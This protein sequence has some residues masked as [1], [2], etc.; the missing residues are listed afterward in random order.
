VQHAWPADQ[1]HT[2]VNLAHDTRAFTQEQLAD[3]QQRWDNV[4]EHTSGILSTLLNSLLQTYWNEESNGRQSRLRLF[5][6]GLRD[7]FRADLL[8]KH[9]A[10]ILST[11][12]SQTLQPCSFRIMPRAALLPAT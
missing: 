5:T 11:A 1:T 7:K 12:E 4:I 3:D 8:L 9:Q 10:T 6:R 2:F